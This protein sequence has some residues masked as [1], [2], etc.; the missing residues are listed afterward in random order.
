M[1]KYIFSIL[2]ILPVLVYS[3][4]YV[5]NPET[6]KFDYYL[7]VTPGSD[8]VINFGSVNTLGNANET[9]VIGHNLIVNAARS[10]AFGYSNNVTESD[11]IVFG[12]Y[13]APDVEQNITI[14][15]GQAAVSPMVNSKYGTV[16]IG[17][18]VSE[19]TLYVQSGYEPGESYVGDIGGVSI[20]GPDLDTL[21]ALQITSHAADGSSYF[22]IMKDSVGVERMTVDDLGNVEIYGVL[23]TDSIVSSHTPT[24]HT[25]A[26]DTS[27]YHTPD[28]VGD[29][30]I[31]ST[32]GDVYVSTGT[33]R[34]D[35]V[36][37]NALLPLVFVIRRKRKLV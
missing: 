23:S 16:G 19:P 21:T 2:L 28:K 31:N 12:T 18:F 5:M 11:N 32:A 26:G 6:G 35:W 27:N 15:R 8:T 3:Q 33:S 4:Y 25:A 10:L 30:F 20:G 9:G 36:K 1:K 7:N 13:L 14:G 37:L 17:Y 24:I 34:G 29:M 22:L